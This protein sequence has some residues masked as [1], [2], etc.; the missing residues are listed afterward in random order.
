MSR[1]TSSRIHHVHFHESGCPPLADARHAYGRSGSAACRQTSLCLRAWSRSHRRWQL[2]HARGDAGHIECVWHQPASSKLGAA[3]RT[4]HDDAPDCRKP[5]AVTQRGATGAVAAR[6]QPSDHQARQRERPLPA[7]CLMTLSA[8][9]QG[10]VVGVK[11]SNSGVVSPEQGR[12]EAAPQVSPRCTCSCC[13]LH[14]VA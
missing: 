11:R 3:Q 9:E 14:T 7:L 13:V 10:S 1:Q 4:A 5:A 8:A 12:R 6:G 2:P